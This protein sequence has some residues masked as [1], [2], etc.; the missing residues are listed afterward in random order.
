MDGEIVFSDHFN[1]SVDNVCSVVSD[2][3]TVVCALSAHVVC[4]NACLRCC[5]SSY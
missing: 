5:Y 1:T 3:H 4:Y 2:V